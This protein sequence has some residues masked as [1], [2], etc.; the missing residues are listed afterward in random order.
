MAG[1]SASEDTSA[2]NEAL[3]RLLAIMARLR[4]ADG[5]PW[6]QAQNFSTISPYTI[7]EAHETAD[8]IHEGPNFPALLDELGD[9]LFQVVFHAQMAREAGHFGFAEIAKAIADKMVRRHP[10][11]FSDAVGIG[12]RSQELAWEGLKALERAAEDKSGTL[13]GISAGL[14]ALSRAAKLTRRAARVGF[15]WSEAGEVLDKAEEEIAELRAELPLA[16]PKRMSDEI[17]DVLFVLANLARKLSLDPEECL[18]QANR[19][20]ERRFQGVEQRLAARGVMP[21]ETTL[22]VMETE[23]QAVKAAERS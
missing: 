2:S 14:P 23:W 4:A 3:S 12:T 22:D 16:D 5:C 21:S 18:R 9:L 10:H 8:A 19:K 17:G 15:D 11:V 20:F 13:A 6:D 1:T 7:E